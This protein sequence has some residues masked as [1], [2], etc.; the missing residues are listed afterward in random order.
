MTRRPST[1][2]RACAVLALCAAPA[3]AAEEGARA[4]DFDE[5]LAAAGRVAEKGLAYLAT[6]QNE[7]GSFSVERGEEAT[8]APLAVTAIAALAFMG[9]GSTLGRGAHAEA[10]QGAIEFLL[11]HQVDRPPQGEGGDATGEM[12]YGYFS[13]ESDPNSRMH[14]HGFATLAVAQAYGTLDVDPG[15]GESAGPKARADKERVRRA[16]VAAVRLIERSQSLQGGWYYNPYEDD[17]EGS[18]TVLMIQALRAARDVGVDVDK[19]VIDRAVRYIHKSQRPE[20]GAFRYHLNSPVVS[21]ALTAAAVAT[22]NAAGNYDSEVIDRGIAYMERHD[23]LLNPDL[24]FSGEQSFPCYARLYAAQA[25]HVHRDP[26]LWHEWYARAVRFLEGR[27][28]RE[29]GC[30]DG[31]QYGRVYATAMSCLVLEL[32]F[33]YLPIFQK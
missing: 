23:P 27:Q 10:V 26:R 9:G 21:Y 25:Y 19:G 2:A 1:L 30:F 15:F 8:Q 22:L 31:D 13:L 7:D 20:D 14:G 33:Q 29:K 18:M 12:R 24:Q 11:A 16:L 4:G 3:A 17:H 5:A 32:P 6:Q 28:H